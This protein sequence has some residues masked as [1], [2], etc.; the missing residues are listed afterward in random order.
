MPQKLKSVSEQ[1]LAINPSHGAALWL[2]GI[3]MME[4]GNQ[5]GARDRWLQ[6]LAILDPKDAKYSKVLEKIKSLGLPKKP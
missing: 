2:N 4:A 6:L 3:A 5:I 1:I